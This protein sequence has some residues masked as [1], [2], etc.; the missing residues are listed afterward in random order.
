MHDIIVENITN[1][2]SIYVIGII[3]PYPFYINFQTRLII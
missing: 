2:N 1:I 3:S